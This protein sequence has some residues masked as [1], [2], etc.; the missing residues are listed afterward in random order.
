MVYP[1]VS[2]SM[3]GWKIPGFWM[4]VS[5]ARKNHRQKWSISQHAMFD[6]RRVLE[7][8]RLNQPP[9]WFYTK[10]N[11]DFTSGNCSLKCFNMMGLLDQGKIMGFR[12]E[13]GGL[14]SKTGS[15]NPAWANCHVS[16]ETLAI[17]KSNNFQHPVCLSSRSPGDSTFPGVSFHLIFHHKLHM[18]RV[19]W[20]YL[21]QDV[22]LA[23][24]ELR[25]SNLWRT[26]SSIFK[27]THIF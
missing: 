8:W 1:L 18:F 16:W 20:K 23:L 22:W 19:R 3:A 2:S 6:D 14:T 13:H 7:K 10:D 9:K 24:S 12:K 15:G 26:V 27:H 25:C 5:F 11:D 21:Q 17:N 4:E